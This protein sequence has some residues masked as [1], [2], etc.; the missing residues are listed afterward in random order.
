MDNKLEDIIRT[1][2]KEGVSLR[3]ISGYLKAKGIMVSHESVRRICRMTP[4]EA[5][6][7]ENVIETS[8]LKEEQEEIER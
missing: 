7:E 5:K 2:K 6:K 3:D 4:E 8:K 1:M